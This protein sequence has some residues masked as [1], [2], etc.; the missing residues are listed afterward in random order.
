MTWVGK[1]HEILQI[2]AVVVILLGLSIRGSSGLSLC[3]ASQGAHYFADLLASRRAS[4]FSYCNF[5]VVSRPAQTA[6]QRRLPPRGGQEIKGGSRFLD[7]S[8][9]R[10]CQVEQRRRGLIPA[11]LWMSKCPC[12]KATKFDSPRSKRL[13][14]CSQ[15]RVGTR[16]G[17]RRLCRTALSK[18]NLPRIKLARCSVLEKAQRDSSNA[19][20]YKGTLCFCAW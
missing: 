17:H 1:A 7:P 16:L 8:N 9:P 18:H 10:A 3:P 13:L 14:T 19:C 2:R 11:R 6:R 15:Q 12:G 5:I 20:R 4:A